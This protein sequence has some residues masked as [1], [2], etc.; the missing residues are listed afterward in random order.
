MS[1]TFVRRR[2]FA[3]LACASV[4]IG[5]L[6]L[7]GSAVAKPAQPRESRTYIG[8]V[9][10]TDAFAAIVARRGVAIAYVCDG[11]KIS[12][13]L[14]GKL[15]HGKFHLASKAGDTLDGTFGHA[16]LDLTTR[17][18]LTVKTKFSP[19][20]DAAHLFIGKDTIDGT[21]WAGGWITLLDGRQRGSLKTGGG[22]IFASPTKVTP[23]T[24]SVTVPG[25]GTLG[26][27]DYFK[28]WSKI[29]ATEG[30]AA[31]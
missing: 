29:P 1:L 5:V 12:V 30:G 28:D 2:R 14:K 6:A 8:T 9:R 25:G 26:V 31:S 22:R 3:A 17:K 4:T 11:K 20:D 13:W 24:T 16:T 23:T 10:G 15:S 27:E 18:P 7:A 19:F 21:T